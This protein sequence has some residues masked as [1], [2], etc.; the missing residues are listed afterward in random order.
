[1]IERR[2]R[3][4]RNKSR[5]PPA[6]TAAS[7]QGYN[8]PHEHPPP[9]A[10]SPAPSYSIF[11]GRG[12]VWEVANTL[13]DICPDAHDDSSCRYQQ[14]TRDKMNK[15]SFACWT[16]TGICCF[17]EE[18]YR[19]REEDPEPTAEFKV[20]LPMV[21]PIVRNWWLGR[22]SANGA[23]SYDECHQHSRAGL[24][25]SGCVATHPYFGD[26]Q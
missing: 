9:P 24:L 12:V 17:F 10:D 18:I 26:N 2:R 1:M 16:C 5:A 21:R 20:F 22:V 8:A 23:S 14:R 7:F 6:W 13:L 3:R 4:R 25:C 15:F 11:L 19:V